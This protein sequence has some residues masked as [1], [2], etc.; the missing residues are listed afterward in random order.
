MLLCVTACV[1]F[2]RSFLADHL[3]FVRPIDD[4]GFS[5]RELYFQSCRG[6]IQFSFDQRIIGSGFYGGAAPYPENKTFWVFDSGS[7]SYPV[8]TFG[9]PPTL[10]ENRTDVRF[11]GFQFVYSH[12][13]GTANYSWAATMPTAITADPLCNPPDLA[14]CASVSAKRSEMVRSSMP[15]P[16]MWL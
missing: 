8:D 14:V 10:Q 3:G 11:L 1:L 2:V 16:I 6:G 15:M 12:Y 7:N 4:T 5:G 9:A 13:I